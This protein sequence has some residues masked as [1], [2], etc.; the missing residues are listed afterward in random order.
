MIQS[1]KRRLAG[2]F[3]AAVA[4]AI[5]SGSL[6]LTRFGVT[7]TLTVY[8]LTAL[9]FAVAAVLLAPLAPAGSFDLVRRRPLTVLV[10]IVGFGAPYVLMISLALKTAPASVAG[11][12]NPGIMA[13]VSVGL[14][15]AF[16]GDRVGGVRLAGLALV[17]AGVAVL[18]GFAGQFGVGEI[19][20]LATGGM[21]AVYAFTVRKFGVPALT[22]T[23]LV[24]IGSAVF[25]L[26]VYLLALPSRIATAPLPDLA[27]QAGF[28]GVLVSA[29]A[30]YAFTRSAELLGPTASAAL[31]SLIPVT[32]LGL[33]LA[34]LGEDAGMVRLAS[35]GL[36]GAGVAAILVGRRNRAVP[37]PED[38]QNGRACETIA[39]PSSINRSISSSPRPASASTS[40][41]CSPS[42][43][44]PCR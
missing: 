26:P 39:T 14:G 27:L 40:L 24:A 3:W 4:I 18:V 29:L 37:M 30:V 11:T 35:A 41:V 5:W 33:G 19:I 22:A 44:P 21:W 8:D 31:P 38:A 42:S 28:Q 9:R 43:G 2:L 15:R 23:A 32:T 25:Y 1:S 7:T 6:V 13:A 20:L 17:A 10:M 34:F 16:F 12:L 36:I